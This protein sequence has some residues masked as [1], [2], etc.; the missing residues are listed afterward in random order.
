V[1]PEIVWPEIEGIDTQDARSRWCNDLALFRSVLER[2][3]DDCS[4]IA[5]PPSDSQ[6]VRLHKLRG[7]ACMLGAKTIQHVAAQAEAA[8]LAGD[9]AKAEE[10]TME[11]VTLLRVLR[12]DAARSFARAE[13]QLP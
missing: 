2:W 9:V 4:D 13:P 8:C 1:W 6:A 11:L 3:I 5:V 7:G 10:R 12:A